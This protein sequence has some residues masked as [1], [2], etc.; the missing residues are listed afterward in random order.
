LFSLA[1]NIACDLDLTIYDA[2]CVFLANELKVPLVTADKT[3]HETAKNG[4]KYYT[5]K[6]ICKFVCYPVETELKIKV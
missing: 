4:S 2:S 6:I 3:L 5:S 1:L